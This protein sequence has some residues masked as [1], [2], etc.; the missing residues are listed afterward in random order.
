MKFKEVILD[1]LEKRGMKKTE[2]S[3]N[4]GISKQALNNQMNDNVTWQLV[5]IDKWLRGLGY[6]VIA[7]PDYTPL[8]K[9]WYE[10]K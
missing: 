4:I 10:L 6:K 7:V 9:D 1:L 2:L 3:N 8:Q 5:T